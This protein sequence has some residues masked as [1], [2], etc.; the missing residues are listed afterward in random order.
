MWD[1]TTGEPA[2]P[3]LQHEA[4]IRYG[5]F[6]P[7]GKHIVTASMDETAQVWE[8]A[9]GRKI[10]P[11]FRHKREVNFAG[12]SADGRRIATASGDQTI[13]IWDAR[14]G[15]PVTGPLL[16]GGNVFGASF[17][18]DG[19]AIASWS[20]A[21]WVNVWNAET[22]ERLLPPLDHKAT[23]FWAKFSPNGR[24]IATSSQ[25]QS[26]RLWDAATG[27][28]VSGPLPHSGSVWK[29][30]F[31]PDGSRILTAAEDGARI[32]KIDRLSWPVEDVTRLAHLLSGHEIDRTPSQ[33]P[34]SAEQIVSTFH[35]LQAKYPEE[36]S[37]QPEQRLAWHRSQAIEAESSGRWAAV[38]WHLSKL[39]ASSP[40]DAALYLRRGDARGELR[41]WELAREDFATE[42][43]LNPQRPHF[44]F[45]LLSIKA[46]KDKKACRELA[47]RLMHWA[48][49]SKT[50]GAKSNAARI[51]SCVPDLL[52]D[53]SQIA[54]WG[55]GDYHRYMLYYRM[56]R[57]TEAADVFRAFDPISSID[58]DYIYYYAMTLFRMGE[59]EKA[60]EAL[61]AGNKKFDDYLKR[62]ITEKLPWSELA[63]CEFA[64]EEAEALI[65]KA[66]P[67][68][69]GA[70]TE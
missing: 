20:L 55:E 36:F 26:A 18:P 68:G 59:T 65:G 25:D 67:D 61:A 1:S 50:G 17:S 4:G 63:V 48:A 5:S 10:F 6:S 52:A 47:Q 33:A 12:Y 11:A 69:N 13:R 60:R 64:R 58:P 22:G 49:D 29:A 34:L 24:F 44:R 16:Q 62:R 30:A 57:D 19:R 41:R 38:N 51:L 56:R 46:G 53:Y 43:E 31:H 7:D 2:G 15:E 39:I 14:T 35:A 8:W 21:P 23:V 28:A 3:F 66:P 9:T 70:R 42:S 27:E 37:E 45:L 32:W 40:E 54:E